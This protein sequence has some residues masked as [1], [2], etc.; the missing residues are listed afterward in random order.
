MYY[1][2]C[3]LS[4]SHRWTDSNQTAFCVSKFSNGLLICTII[5]GSRPWWPSSPRTGTV[6]LRLDMISG[7]LRA[8]LPRIDQ[9]V[10]KNSDIPRIKLSF[11]NWFMYYTN[12]ANSSVCY[13]NFKYILP[14]YVLLKPDGVLQD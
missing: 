8:K 9:L 1:T 14:N 4:S 10:E 6:S 2:F 3:C 12:V 11:V 13:T 7:V 5:K